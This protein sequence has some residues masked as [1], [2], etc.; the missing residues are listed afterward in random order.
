MSSGAALPLVLCYQGTHKWV[1]ADF[2][3]ESVHRQTITIG[4]EHTGP[5]HSC[6]KFDTIFSLH[7]PSFTN[8][9]FHLKINLHH[10]LKSPAIMTADTL[11]NEFDF[12]LN[13][14]ESNR[15]N[16]NKTP[17]KSLATSAAVVSPEPADSPSVSSG[18]SVGSLDDTNVVN[19]QVQISKHKL[20]ELAGRH[21]EEPLLKENPGRFVLFPIQDN[22]VSTCISCHDTYGT[23]MMCVLL[24]ILHALTPLALSLLTDMEHVQEGRG[25][26]LDRRRN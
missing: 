9:S 4:A 5:P 26:I 1:I 13:L 18:S 11:C 19:K 6:M 22:D 12:T 20:D 7:T 3:L 17:A 23:H 15:M 2:S 16:V 8:S 24:P 21:L 10:P 25:I 14:D